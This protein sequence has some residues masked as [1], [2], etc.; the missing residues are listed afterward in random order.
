MASDQDVDEKDD[1]ESV[2]NP[3]FRAANSR[4]LI[5]VIKA[6]AGS[7][8]SLRKL[9][10]FMTSVRRLSLSMLSRNKGS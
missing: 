6:D 2:K 9:S 5:S 7:A 10:V 1:D 8:T 4:I 3:I